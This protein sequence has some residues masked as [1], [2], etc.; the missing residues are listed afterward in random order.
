MSY[1]P[2]ELLAMIASLEKR[3]EQN[4]KLIDASPKKFIRDAQR[5]IDSDRFTINKL[6]NQLNTTTT[7][8]EK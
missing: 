4:Q 2:T 6:R 8:K 1:R 7:N 5:I 3:I